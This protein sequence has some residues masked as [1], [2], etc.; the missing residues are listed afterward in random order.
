MGLDPSVVAVCL[1]LARRSRQRVGSRMA[2]AP[3]EAKAARA[4]TKA[5]VE[6]MNE[7]AGKRLGPSAF[8]NVS[9]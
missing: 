4:E 3:D 6:Q 8:Q 7:A 5:A 9:R 2:S 1:L